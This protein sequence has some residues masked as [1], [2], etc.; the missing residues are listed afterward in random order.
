MEEEEDEAAPS[1]PSSMGTSSVRLLPFPGSTWVVAIF[2]DVFCGTCS[3]GIFF[4]FCP[5]LLT[6]F[7]SLKAFFMEEAGGV[8]NT[9]EVAVATGS[10]WECCA[11]ASEAPK[12]GESAFS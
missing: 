6:V 9:E 1:A 4:S 11:I 8:G 10:T 2:F 3:S 5:L 7:C 12:K